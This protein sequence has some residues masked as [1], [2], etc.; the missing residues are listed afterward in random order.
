MSVGEDEICTREKDVVGS[1]VRDPSG[2]SRLFPYM[3]YLNEM[4]L[5]W[6]TDERVGEGLAIRL[7]RIF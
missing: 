7:I 2:R 1:R 4:D 5:N 6:L 3:V